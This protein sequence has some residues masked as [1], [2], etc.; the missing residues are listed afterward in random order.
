M[1]LSF[2]LYR[3]DRSY[4]DKLI[5]SFKEEWIHE[6]SRAW[7]EELTHFKGSNN[8]SRF[9]ST[10]HMPSTTLARAHVQISNLK[11]R[12]MSQFRAMSCSEKGD[13]ILT[14]GRKHKREKRKKS[15]AALPPYPPYH[16]AT[17]IQPS[18][19]FLAS[20]DHAELGPHS[21]P[22]PSVRRPRH[23]K[24]MQLPRSS[25]KP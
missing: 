1:S 22:L 21:P 11:T 5:E 15:K 9:E 8:P 2:L 20:R 25:H 12:S 10:H 18:R 23:H 17:P 16:T 7:V 24:K 6:P 4:R 13:M 19:P 14:Q 3:T